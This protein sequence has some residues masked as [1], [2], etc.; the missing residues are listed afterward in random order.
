MLYQLIED[1]GPLT[2]EGIKYVTYLQFSAL[3]FPCT[4][5]PSQPTNT[6]L[7]TQKNTGRENERRWEWSEQEL[8]GRKMQLCIQ[9]TQPF[10]C[11]LI[12]SMASNAVIRN[13]TVV[14]GPHSAWLPPWPIPDSPPRR[15][16][17]NSRLPCHTIL[18]TH[19][20][21][22]QVTRHARPTQSPYTFKMYHQMPNALVHFETDRPEAT[23]FAFACFA[24]V[25]LPQ[26]R[27]HLP[28]YTALRGKPLYSHYS[29]LRNSY[30]V[31]FDSSIILL[32]C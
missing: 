32:N 26:N 19:L 1:Y 24:Y 14:K 21:T 23:L 17:N 2:E 30:L 5:K 6:P 22:H 12:Y 31:F 9:G 7:H 18:L 13:T 8:S 10:L 15:F 11:V 20:Q 16:W 4:S 3:S 29:F 27:G 28:N 25:V